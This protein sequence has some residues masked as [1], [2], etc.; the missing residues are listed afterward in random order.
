[1]K[2]QMSFIFII[3]VFS[4]KGFPPE[5]PAVVFDDRSVYLSY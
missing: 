1:M 5:C 2:L 4:G 3:G